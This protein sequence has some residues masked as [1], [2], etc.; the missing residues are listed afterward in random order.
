MITRRRPVRRRQNPSSPTAATWITARARNALRRPK[1]IGVVSVLT[2]AGTLV[3]LA[4][5]PQQAHKAAAALRPT[6]IPRPDTEPTVRELLGAG[7]QAAA[8]E[9]TLARLRIEIAQLAAPVV[10]PTNSDSGA[11]A[12]PSV[13]A[14][15]RR[16]SL[17]SQISLLG[18]LIFRSENAPLLA[19]YRALAQAA[20]M[21]GDVRVKQL[22]D[23]LVEIERERDSYTAVG[24]VDPV[25]VALTARANELGHDIEGLAEARRTAL[26]I[27]V[28]A[29][30]PPP[31]AVVGTV[32]PRSPP[33]TTAA[34]HERDAA[35]SAMAL[36]SA[37]LARQRTV[38]LQLDAREERARELGNVG[39]SPW[40]IL[41]TAALFGAVLGFGIALYDEVRHPRIADAHEVERAT[42]VRVLG[43]I[44]RLPPSPERGRRSTDRLGPTYIDS[45]TDGHHLIYLTIATA[46]ANTIMLT[47]TGD[48][49]AISAVVAINFVAIAADEGRSTLLI[50]TDS[51][52]AGVTTA[53]QLSSNTGV[54]GLAN[55][56]TDWPDVTQSI[57]LGRDRMIDVV[58]SG[59]G[60]TSVVEISALLQ[61]DMTRLSQ[62]YDAIVLVS[63]ESQVAEGLSVAL[64]ISDVIYC[65][66][67]GQTPVADL[68]RAVESITRSGAQLRGIVLWNAP[69]PEPPAR[70]T[71][72]MPER[73]TTTV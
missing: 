19:S 49:A 60:A 68:A 73:Q 30:A 59:V 63:A 71:I 33:D 48:Q 70:N 72:E 51:A 17:S 29:L 55:A 50:D 31:P 39:A 26:G 6:A 66:R 37:Q 57:R 46:G 27:Q 24:G 36:A 21:Q 13:D 4:I 41:A 28:A 65:A 61:R 43:E 16:D 35:R 25:F 11:V 69:P 8:A 38:L 22:L 2:F 42:G 58:P 34:A 12:V 56:T 52:A 32:L 47:V 1:A 54:N 44:R 10:R 18:R 5:V 15:K 40:A 9:S 45:G 62:R 67:A 7:E 20:P 64:P 53:L 14:R 23:S 3:A